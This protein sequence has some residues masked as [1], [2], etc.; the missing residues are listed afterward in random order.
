MQFPSTVSKDMRKVLHEMA[1][2]AGLHSISQVRPRRPPGHTCIEQ[3]LIFSTMQRIN[4]V[5]AY[6]CVDRVSSF[7]VSSCVLTCQPASHA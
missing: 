1:Q 2:N 4:V 5:C 7:N 6:T 3:A